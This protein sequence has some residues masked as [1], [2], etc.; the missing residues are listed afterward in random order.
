MILSEN[1]KFIFIAVPKTGTTSLEKVLKPYDSFGC[2]GEDWAP[3][4]VKHKPARQLR[5]ELGEERWRS[6]FKF[7]FVRNPWERV[8][9]QYFYLKSD[10]FRNPA[11]PHH[12][13]CTAGLSFDAF[14]RKP[15]PV[16]SQTLYLSDETG[17]LLVDFV[18][19]Y[20]NIEED[21]QRICRQL[22]LSRIVLPHMNQSWHLPYPHYY[23][24]ETRRVVEKRFQDDI[25]VFGFRFGARTERFEQCLSDARGSA[26]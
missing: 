11:S 21:W 3:P 4:P 12:R 26:V 2:S 14:I 10:I 7:S 6:Y 18:G 15:I 19:Y 23:N 22:G 17:K 5:A 13:L 25:E 9:S 16:D 24:S 20:E 1:L 8:V